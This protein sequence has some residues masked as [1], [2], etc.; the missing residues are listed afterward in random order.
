[1]RRFLSLVLVFAWSAAF[2]AEPVKLDIYSVEQNT[3]DA[4]RLNVANRQ[5]RQAQ[6]FWFL[7]FVS[8]NNFALP[9]HQVPAARILS[10]PDFERFVT[11]MCNESSKH[12]MTTIAMEFVLRNSPPDNAPA[13][14]R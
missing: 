6:Y 2:S 8:G 9:A 12:T 14:K 7:G 5:A 4:W 11:S 1:M 10:E 3:C 13:Q